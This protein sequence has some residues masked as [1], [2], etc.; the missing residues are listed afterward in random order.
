MMLGVLNPIIGSIHLGG[1]TAIFNPLLYFPFS[2]HNL[3]IL[4]YPNFN[5]LL[6]DIYPFQMVL[7]PAPATTFLNFG[8]S[9]FANLQ[10]IH[11]L[12]ITLII[13]SRA[14]FEQQL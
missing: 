6:A 3:H 4:I 7:K 2:S 9:L 11:Q 13:I 14:E 1:N 12:G 5:A 8:S 10:Q